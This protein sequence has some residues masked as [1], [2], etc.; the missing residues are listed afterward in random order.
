M[1]ARSP[2]YVQVSDALTERI[3]QGRYDIGTFLP[4]EIELCEEFAVSRHTV[5]EALRRLADAGLVRRRQGSGSQVVASHPHQAYVHEMRSLAGLFQYATDTRFQIDRMGVAVPDPAT[6]PALDGREREP[7]LIV[8]GLRLDPKDESAICV[9]TVHIS[10]DFAAIAPDLLRH[11][12]AIYSL[13]EERFGVQVADVEQHISALQMPFE[14]AR[15]L[16]VSRKVWAVRVVR[17][18]RDGEGKLM[19][20]SVNHHPADRFTYTMHLR[21]EGRGFG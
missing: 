7:W 6:A 9:S 14:A 19:L 2:R 17:L 11:A 4:T 5:R 15:A 1:T 3:A 21:R 16:G 18:Y 20:A 10:R 13:I 12:G 8:E